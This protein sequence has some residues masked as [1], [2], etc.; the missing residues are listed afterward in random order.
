MLA[1][2]WSSV[3]EHVLDGDPSEEIVRMA[4]EWPADLVVNAPS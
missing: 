4:D 2:R 1:K 3:E